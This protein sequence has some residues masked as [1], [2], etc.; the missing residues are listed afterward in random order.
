[1]NSLESVSGQ[2]G[3]ELNLFECKK[4]LEERKQTIGL[5]TNSWELE[6]KSGKWHLLECEL[7]KEVC[8]GRMFKG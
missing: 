2:A 6:E 5:S 8:A 1:M 4:Q 7:S 3:K